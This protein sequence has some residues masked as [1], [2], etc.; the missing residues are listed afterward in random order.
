MVSRRSN[1]AIHADP[2]PDSAPVAAEHLDLALVEAVD[3]ERWA[4]LLRDRSEQLPATDSEQFWSSVHELLQ[5]SLVSKELKDLLQYL[6]DLGDEQG[7]EAILE[8]VESEQAGLPEEARTDTPPSLVVRLWC[9][10]ARTRVWLVVL[11]LA[12]IGVT[13]KKKLGKSLHEYNGSGRKPRDIAP[14]LETTLGGLLEPFLKSRGLVLQE[15][16]IREYDSRITVAVLFG[17]REQMHVL[18]EDKRRERRRQRWAHCDVIRYDGYE[19]RLSVVSRHRSLFKPYREAT[20]KV[21][22]GD[23][24]CFKDGPLWSFEVLRGDS[25]ARFEKAREEFGLRTLRVRRLVWQPDDGT[26]VTIEGG[27]VL[28]HLRRLSPGKEGTLVETELELLSSGF[29]I[30]RV[31]AR[32]RLPDGLECPPIHR[33]LL[34]RVADAL[35]FSLHAKKHITVWSVAEGVFPASEFVLAFRQSIESLEKLRIVAKTLREFFIEPDERSAGEFLLRE[36]PGEGPYALHDGEHGVAAVRT[37][38]ADTDAWRLL[39]EALVSEF[40]KALALEG[41]QGQLEQS[42]LWDAG[43]LRVGEMRVRV[44]LVLHHP[45]DSFDSRVAALQRQYGE[46]RVVLVHPVGVRLQTMHPCVDCDDLISP[47]SGTTVRFLRAAGVAEIPSRLLAGDVPLAIAPATRTVLVFGRELDLPE[48]Q[49]DLLLKLAELN[50][51]GQKLT[52]KEL[53][54]LLKGKSASGDAL[55]GVMK[56]LRKRLEEAARESGKLKPKQALFKM[57]GKAFVLAVNPLVLSGP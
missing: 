6:S 19:D 18:A 33:G 57:S 37:A 54:T 43:I 5:S 13:T 30:N 14:D 46:E 3:A 15:V 44:L 22:F 7:Q 51:R 35:G 47:H 42:G 29:Q 52:A 4:E 21:I 26:R 39:P 40:S 10:G 8:A 32:F 27:R 50:K 36:A 49:F 56:D 34:R 11:K 17:G 41:A 45:H 38:P 28:E 25:E 55:R 12:W 9:L 16:R 20:G 1:L 48:G 24:N 23:Q 2:S 31:R 53:A